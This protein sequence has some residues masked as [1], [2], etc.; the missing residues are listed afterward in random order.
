MTATGMTSIHWRPKGLAVDFL[1]DSSKH[2]FLQ[3]VHP[4][5]KSTHTYSSKVE[6]EHSLP[7]AQIRLAGEGSVYGTSERL[8]YSATSTRLQYVEHREWIKC[9]D[10]DGNDGAGEDI[11]YLEIVTIDT[12]TRMEVRC[13]YSVFGGIPGEFNFAEIS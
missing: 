5:E 8:V 6:R 10:S 2:I 3:S 11:H 9:R 4:E 1:I 13:R 12:V 7:L